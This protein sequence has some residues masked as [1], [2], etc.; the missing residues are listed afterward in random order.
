M[1]VPKLFVVPLSA[2]YPEDTWGM[3][4]GSMVHKINTQGSGFMRVAKLHVHYVTK[5][6]AGL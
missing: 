4:L 6:K 2:G 5:I 1:F 3:K